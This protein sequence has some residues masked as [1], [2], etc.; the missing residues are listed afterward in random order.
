MLEELN[1]EYELKVY[2]RGSDKLAP[3]ELKDIHPLGKSPIVSIQAPGA[4]K[5]IILAESGLI[6]EYLAVPVER[7][8]LLSSWSRQNLRSRRLEYSSPLSRLI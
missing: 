1:L 2:K 8:Q 6:I 4:E 7:L 5:P 3:K